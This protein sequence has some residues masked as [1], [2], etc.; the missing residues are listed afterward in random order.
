MIQ[1]HGIGV[2]DHDEGGRPD[3]PHTSGYRSV[4]MGKVINL[5]TV[6]KRAA[7]LRDGQHAAERRAHYGMSK[8]ER[9]LI[10]ARDE[11]ARRNVDDHQI[12]K[13]EGR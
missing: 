7:R 4:R 11:K 13:G 9:L 1:R 8:A 12:E 3:P 2:T 5:R 10:K 6:R